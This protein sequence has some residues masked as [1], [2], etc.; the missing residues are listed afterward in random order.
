MFGVTSHGQEESAATHHSHPQQ[1]PLCDPYWEQQPIRLFPMEVGD[2][3][4]PMVGPFVVNDGD[5]LDG[6]AT[7]GQAAFC[8]FLFAS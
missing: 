6:L 2:V 8:A 3:V 7:F 5:G 1:P 4:D